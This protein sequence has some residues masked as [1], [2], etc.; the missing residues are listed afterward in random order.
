ML[1]GVWGSAP[2]RSR[3]EVVR[4]RGSK[5]GVLVRLAAWLC[6]MTVLAGGCGS[7][8]PR[9]AP[10]PHTAEAAGGADGTQAQGAPE[11]PPPL[12]LVRPP[13]GARERVDRWTFAELIPLQRWAAVPGR[14]IG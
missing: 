2:L 9:A 14:V 10:A 4:A 12:V 13:P 11:A 3:R 6:A 1:D 7:S 5:M 8:P